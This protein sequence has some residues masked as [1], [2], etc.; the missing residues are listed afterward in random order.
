MLAVEEVS[1]VGCELLVALNKAA[2]SMFLMNKDKPFENLPVVFC[3]D[4]NQLRLAYA[5][6]IT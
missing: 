6:C 2:C 5:R 4:F 1:M 3:G